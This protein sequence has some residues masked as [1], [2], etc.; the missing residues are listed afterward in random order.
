LDFWRLSKDDDRQAIQKPE[1]ILEF[2]PL[3]R[4]KAGWLTELAAVS[5]LPYCRVS[6]EEVSPSKKLQLGKP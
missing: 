3:Q 6:H 5:A 2:K 1:V 4:R